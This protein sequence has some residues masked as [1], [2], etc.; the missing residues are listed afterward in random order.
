MY[1]YDILIIPSQPSSVGGFREVART[2]LV[3]H[4]FDATV[5]FDWRLTP[6]FLM[7]RATSVRLAKATDV[8]F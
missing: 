6:P 5:S 1:E 8:R 3:R 7:L 4:G 2:F